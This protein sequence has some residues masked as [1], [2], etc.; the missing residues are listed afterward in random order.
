MIFLDS[1]FLV[2][3]EVEGDINHSK[4]AKLMSHIARAIYGTPF[5]SDYV[6]D[7]VVTVTFLRT[8]NLSKARLIGDAMLKAFDVLKVDDAIFRSAWR[9]FRE[10]K[11]TKFSFTD[12]T[13]AE[14]MQ[15]NAIENIATFDRDFQETHQFVVLGQ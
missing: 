2:A 6:F 14:L 3:F 7:E 5:I 13:T 8:K 10:Q 12:A 11:D 1:S 9:R 15:Q 4:A